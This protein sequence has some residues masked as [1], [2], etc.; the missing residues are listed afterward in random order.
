MTAREGKTR[1][2]LMGTWHQLKGEMLQL[3][4]VWRFLKGKGRL[5]RILLACLLMIM[6]ITYQDTS[7]AMQENN[8]AGMPSYA[9]F[10]EIDQNKNFFIVVGDTQRTSHW[11]FWREKSE[12]ERRLISYRRDHQTRPSFCRTSWGPHDP[13]QFQKT[14]GRI[15]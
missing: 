8:L 9:G 14:L 15:R 7:L 5:S 10:A 1:S 3:S 2:Y 13:R 12:R 11:E 4:V 6:T